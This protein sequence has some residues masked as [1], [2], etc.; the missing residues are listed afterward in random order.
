MSPSHPAVGDRA[1]S[2]CGSPVKLGNVVT[3][4]K[5]HVN[6]ETVSFPSSTSIALFV[7]L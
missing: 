3:G 2:V 7:M 5:G 1:R 6:V 4:F